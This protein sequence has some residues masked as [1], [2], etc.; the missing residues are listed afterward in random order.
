LLLIGNNNKFRPWAHFS[1][2][3]IHPVCGGNF[4][5]FRKATAPK[6]VQIFG[7]GFCN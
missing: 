4:L 3:G 6:K 7:V 2:Y 5:H 1:F